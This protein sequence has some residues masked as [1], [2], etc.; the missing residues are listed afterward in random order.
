MIGDLVPLITQ[1]VI[2]YLQ[3]THISKGGINE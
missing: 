1:P 3:N 2:D